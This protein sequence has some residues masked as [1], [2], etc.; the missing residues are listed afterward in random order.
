[1]CYKQR[2]HIEA[3]ISYIRADTFAIA[4]SHHQSH[5]HVHIT[6]HT[7][8]H[9]TH[10]HITHMYTSHTCTHH[11][12]HMYTSHTC[13][14]HITHM[15]TCTHHTHV[16]ITHMYTSHHTHV[17]ITHMYTSHTCTHHTHVHITHITHHTHHTALYR[18]QTL[19]LPASALRALVPRLVLKTNNKNTIYPN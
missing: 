8:T 15:Y 1:M 18:Q 12:T 7:C 11:I 16:H 6:S 2:S 9:H 5:T 13:T 17:Y 14:H 19:S 3:K 4:C 10:V